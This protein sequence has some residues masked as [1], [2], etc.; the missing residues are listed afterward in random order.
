MLY[1]KAIDSE[2]R[3]FVKALR[4]RQIIPEKHVEKLSVNNNST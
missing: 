3:V 4:N 2:V 1:R